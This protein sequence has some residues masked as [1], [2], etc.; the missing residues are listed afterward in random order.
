MRTDKAP[1]RAAITA[2]ARAHGSSLVAREHQA[3]GLAKIDQRKRNAR[4][5]QLR[6]RAAIDS[7]RGFRTAL[8]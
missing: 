6:R 1:Q 2:P 8:T 4:K 3:L 5:Q 7:D